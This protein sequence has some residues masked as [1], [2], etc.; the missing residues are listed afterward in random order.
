MKLLYIAGPFNHEDTIHG[1]ARNIIAASE[2]ALEAARKGWMPL[3]PHKNTSDFQH[4]TDIPASFWYEGDIE[5]LKRCDA[6]LLIPGWEGSFGAMGEAA[7]AERFGILVYEYDVI[8][9]PSV[10]VTA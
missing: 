3:C 9:I 8:G 4:A 5:I 2:V 7:A 1:I 10:E 6:V